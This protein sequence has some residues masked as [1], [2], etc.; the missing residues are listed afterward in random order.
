MAKRK[1]KSTKK[2]KSISS[3]RR[4]RKKALLVGVN[5]YKMQGADLR[6]CVND[7]ANIKDAIEQ[8]CGFDRNVRTLVDSK[9]TT[10]RIKTEM[11]RLVDG[12]IPGDVLFM[13]FS[14]HGSNVPDKS[15]D[16]ADNRDEILCPT[17]LDWS[18]PLLDDFIRDTFDSL[19]SRVNLTVIFDCCHSGTATRAILPPDTKLPLQ[20][21]L[22]CPLDI[23]AV[24]SG[25]SL[26]GKSR[27][28][29]ARMKRS[30]QSRGKAKKDVTTLNTPEVLISGCRDDQT[31]A[32][33]YIAG[34]FNGALT[35]NLVKSIKAGRGKLTCRELHAKTLSRVK[36]GKYEQTPQLS[37]KAANIDRVFLQS[38]V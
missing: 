12:A 24:E 26:T 2:K 25:R 23:M 32:D 31:S 36:K 4:P 34:S 6:G 37:G 5:K 19:P 7:V 30:A 1:K 18:D 38:Y 3:K 16:E 9:A 33:A 10:R 15:G 17:D 14:G 28:K 21:Y 11:E 35:Y 8:Y 22:P 29:N 20:R 13:H 27:G